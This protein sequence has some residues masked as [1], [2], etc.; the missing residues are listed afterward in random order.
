MKAPEKSVK[1]VRAAGGIVVREA[2][3][4][5]IAIV[6]LRKDKTWVLPKGKLKPDEGARAAAKREVLE[7]TGHDVSVHEFLGSMSHAAGSKH[8]IVQFW[9]MR[10]VGGPVH[11]LMRD[12]RA[13]K[14]L[15]LE[16]AVETLTH[17][18]E[19]AF[20]ADVG[21]AALKAAA[22]SARHVPVDAG[23]RS[24]RAEAGGPAARST[25]IDK[26]RAWFRRMTQGR[27]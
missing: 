14:W 23:E 6:R 10:A 3:E 25:F 4:P 16:Q 5:L 9:R 13:V 27:A 22:R 20:L 12:V 17:A 26:I 1:P 2:P 15:P 11:K 19:Q 24:A 21:P 7:E 8:K 18:H